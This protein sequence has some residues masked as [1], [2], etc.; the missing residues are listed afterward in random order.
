MH[1]QCFKGREAFVLDLCLESMA[2]YLNADLSSL[3]KVGCVSAPLPLQSVCACVLESVC[4]CFDAALWLCLPSSPPVGC[5]PS[6]SD[7]A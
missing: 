3:I 6:G 4:A 1:L 7:S 5:V 2:C